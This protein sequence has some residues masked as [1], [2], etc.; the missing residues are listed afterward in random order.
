MEMR[1]DRSLNTASNYK[2]TQK[3]ELGREGE[4]LAQDV[5]NFLLKTFKEEALF[6]ACIQ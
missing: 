6:C 4:F 3:R 5:E 1:N 2:P